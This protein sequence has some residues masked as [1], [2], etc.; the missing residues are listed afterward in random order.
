M[1]KKIFYILRVIPKLGYGNSMYIVGYKLSMRF[2]FR[3]KFFPVGKPVIGLFFK[4]CEPIGDYPEEWKRPLEKRAND[5]VN[6]KYKW[7][8]YHDFSVANPPH[9]FLNPFTGEELTSRDKHWTELS[10]FDMNTGDVKILWELSRFDWVTDLARA[11]RVFGDKRY[12][13]ALNNRL[14][15]WSNNN[16]LNQGPN[17]KCGQETSIRVMKLFTAATILKQADVTSE[18]LKELI[19]HHLVRIKSNIRYAIAQDNNHGTSES[20]GLYIGSMWLLNQ[21]SIPEKRRKGLMKWKREGRARLEERLL[22]LI[23]DDGTFAQKSVTYHRVVMDTMSCV[24]QAMNF[25]EEVPFR[26]A[27]NHKIS[28]LASW[29]YK[30]MIPHEGQAPNIGANDGALFENIH[31][32]DYRDFRPSVQTLYGLTEEIKV[33]KDGPWNEPL[34]WRMHERYTNLQQKQVDLPAAELLDNQFLR[35]NKQEFQVFLII[36][37]DGFRLGNDLFHIDVWYKGRNI[38]IDSGSYSYNDP[39]STTKFQSIKAHNTIQF[40]DHEPMPTISRFLNGEWIK[41][42]LNKL[43]QNDHEIVWEGRY[44]DFKGNKHHRV[45]SVHSDHIVIKD[46]VESSERATANF[47][48]D[49]QLTTSDHNNFIFKDWSISFDGST[50]IELIKSEH[51]LYYMQKQSH[52]VLSVALDERE[53]I[54]TIN[55]N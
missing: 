9:W 13:D 14:K 26:V 53:L 2:G 27:I 42:T 50:N 41:P 43:I 29:M 16:P 37:D 39:N 3:K 49:D 31:S 54:T 38:L 22:Y 25:F 47:H 30:M 7:F 1:I 8:H 44:V 35:I 21:S 17:W 15:D 24:L 10:D 23:A 51:S 40:D 28:R 12:L 34:F 55:L 48:I 33:F 52:L 4:S 32:C 6:G 45:L 5:I 11:Y 18:S 36:P 46:R 19:W 20:A